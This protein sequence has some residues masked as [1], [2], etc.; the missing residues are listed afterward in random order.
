MLLYFST[1]VI[2]TSFAWAFFKHKDYKPTIGTIPIILLQ[3]ALWPLWV[4]A[5]GLLV[6][7]AMVGRR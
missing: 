3:I 5:I 1:G 4:G 2:I 6:V 7:L